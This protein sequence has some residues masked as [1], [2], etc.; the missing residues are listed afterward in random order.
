MRKNQH[1]GKIPK[2]F[3]VALLFAVLFWLLIKLSKEYK[4]VISFPVEY[5]NIPQ[6]KLI[7]KD[8]LKELD[9]QIKASGFRLIGLSLFNKEIKLN[10][11][12]LQKKTDTDYYFLL[13]SQLLN[14]QNQISNNYVVDY[15][16]QDT[17]FL[18]L[19]T[20]T[21]KKIALK[22]NFDLTYKLGYH[23]AKPIK[24]TP[25][26]ILVS[27]PK[28]QIDTLQNLYLQ[29]M[30]LN[31][32]FESFN[33]SLKIN[34]ASS[35]IKFSVKEAIVFGE[36]DQFTEG[37]LEIPFEIIN[38][39]D[40]ISVNTFPTLVKVVFQTGLTNFNKVNS[41][42]FKIVCDFQQSIDNNLNYLIPKVVVKPDYVTSV[43][44]TPNKVE[45]LI[46]K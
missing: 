33:E 37:N 20:L 30:T 24:V 34:E 41:S 36:I 46:Q 4:T 42:S 16:V 13:Q 11:S 22:G 2:A 14:I 29:K 45:Y 15:L 25:D 23:L 5:V 21:S 40:S 27:G 43:K 17:V 7:Q 8:P 12:T 44:V 6:D 35:A 1:Q 28:E 31:N 38:M 19:G 32:V 39:P 10:A 9:I 18:N 26:S 3:T